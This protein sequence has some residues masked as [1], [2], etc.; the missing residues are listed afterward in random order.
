MGLPI[1]V[2][3]VSVYAYLAVSI[4]VVAAEKIDLSP[5]RQPDGLTQVSVE[6]E[7]TGSTLVRSESDEKASKTPERRLPMNATARLRYAER[8]F[9]GRNPGRSGISLLAVRYYELAE[10]TINVDEKAV[11]PRLAEDRR[12]IV[13][14]SA[15]PRPILYSP[16]GPLKREELDLV[17]VLASS[18]VIDQ[19]LP[20]KA[21][22]DGDSW[23]AEPAAV[24]ALLTLD[25]IAVCEVQSVLEEFNANFA[26]VRVAGV[27]H[28]TAEGAAT[29]Q[30]IRGVYL[31]D[32]NLRR[33]TRLNLAL[34]EK[35]SIGGATP[36]LDAVAKLQIKLEPIK[37]CP[38][39]DDSNIK[40]LAPPEGGILLDLAYDAPTL[41][42]Q[43]RHDRQWFITSEEREAVTLRRVDGND[44]VAQCT[45]VSLPPKSAGRQTTLEQFQKDVLYSLGKNVGEL[46]RTRQ[47][48]NSHEH[49][50]YEVVVRGKVEQMPVEWHHFLV[51]RESGHRVSLA[52]TVEGPMVERV[53]SADRAVVERLKL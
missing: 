8:N 3:F 37:S 27:V 13:V 28:G 22:A 42:F 19:L 1:R 16:K 26:K 32:R 24:A 53:A 49:Y 50:C 12:L 25:S 35:R 30:E 20:G 21:V 45:L 6:L 51:A 10:A 34:R 5:L 31:F 18:S 33:I 23:P 43:L 48:Q 40:T 11:A 47:W 17:D 4:S 38:Q 14:A 39:L 52:V 7:A 46:V 44:V 41:G 2:A 36:G 15:T 29:E 9:P